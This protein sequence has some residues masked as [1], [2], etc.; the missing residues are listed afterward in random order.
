MLNLVDAWHGQ[1]ALAPPG[2]A[3]IGSH[4]TDDLPESGACAHVAD[5]RTNFAGGLRRTVDCYY[6]TKKRLQVKE[7]LDRML[8]ER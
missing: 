7:I 6:G 3:L 4:L 1:H 2:A 5:S 8:T